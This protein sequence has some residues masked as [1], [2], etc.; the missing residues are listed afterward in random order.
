MSVGDKLLARNLAPSD[1]LSTYDVVIV[2]ST[3]FGLSHCHV[4]KYATVFDALCSRDIKSTD[5]QVNKAVVE[6]CVG[7]C[8][9]LDSRVIVT[10]EFSLHGKLLLFLSCICEVLES[11]QHRYDVIVEHRIFKDREY[12][13]DD[14]VVI[15]GEHPAIVY[16]LKQQVSPTLQDQSDDDVCEFFIQCYY[17]T[18]NSPNSWFCLTDVKDFHYFKFSRKTEHLTIEQYFYLNTDVCDFVSTNEHMSFVKENMS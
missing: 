3:I 6:E 12:A 16:E 8:L 1:R 14:A 10:C 13:V 4:S 7:G 9:S 5:V 17:I 2:L 11:D 18:R 15:E